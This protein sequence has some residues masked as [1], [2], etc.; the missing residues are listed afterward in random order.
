MKKKILVVDDEKDICGIMKRILENEGY[1]VFEAYDGQEALSKVFEISPDIMVIDVQMPGKNGFQVCEEIR[2][3]PIYK[4][5][6]I[7]MLT[8]RNSKEDRLQGF[9]S[10]VDEYMVKPFDMSEIVAR[11][12]VVLERS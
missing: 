9:T 2:K 4:E 5:L 7:L 12:K 8:V 3:D 10:G 11:I 1:A 6:P